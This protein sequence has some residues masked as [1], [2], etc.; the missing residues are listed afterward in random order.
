MHAVNQY[1]LHSRLV[2]LGIL[3][4]GTGAAT[5]SRICHRALPLVLPGIKP[6]PPSLLQHESSVGWKDIIGQHFHYNL[7]LSCLDCKCL[8]GLN[9]R[10]WVKS[11]IH[12]V[13]CSS[14]YV[15]VS[16]T[17]A[18]I[19]MC[20][21]S[22]CQLIWTVYALSFY[23]VAWSWHRVPQTKSGWAPPCKLVGVAAH[24]HWKLWCLTV[25]GVQLLITYC[26]YEC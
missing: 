5:P 17:C 2:I 14:V 11:R 10:W 18:T 4:H 23:W 9:S 7:H 16:R 24:P 19:T 21:Q 3:K 22:N 12:G 25:H 20:T 13:T 1:H 8:Q 6:S 15:S 26:S